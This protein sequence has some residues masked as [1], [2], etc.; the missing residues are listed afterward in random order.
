MWFRGVGKRI[1]LKWKALTTV[2]IT[3]TLLI[4]LTFITSAFVVI[5]VAAA[6]YEQYVGHLASTAALLMDGDQF[7]ALEAAADA[8]RP[9]DG[10]TKGLLT[11]FMQATPVVS[12][13][14]IFRLLPAGRPEIALYVGSPDV[15]QMEE[16]AGELGPEQLNPNIKHT[17]AEISPHSLLWENQYYG[18]APILDKTGREVGLLGI[19]IYADRLDDSEQEMLWGMLAIFLLSLAVNVYLAWRR[20]N[21]WIGPVQ[22]LVAGVQKI[23]E[24]HREIRFDIHTGDEFELIGGALNEAANA[25]LASEKVL[26]NQLLAAEQAKQ[27]IFKVYSDVIFAVTQGKFNLCTASQ[28][29][30]LLAEGVPCNR[31]RIALPEDVNAG[32]QAVETLLSG[33]GWDKTQSTKLILCV[34]EAATNIVKHAQGGEMIVYQLADRM[35]VAFSDQGAGM[36]YEKLPHMIFLKGFSTKISLGCGFSIMYK[37]ADKIYL[38]TSE[39]GTGLALDFML[40]VT[41]PGAR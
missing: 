21:V 16:L 17:I 20:V 12:Q 24:G 15:A 18:Y 32:R 22:V 14:C 35:R 3:L 33:M 26:E 13:I 11:K 31:T 30:K 9:E 36:D 29:A 37:Y 34:S 8:Q 2:F 38:T 7:P 10:K 23:K 19:R 4:T 41:A 40:P 39:Q 1:S 28:L 25:M 5:R 6:R 27:K